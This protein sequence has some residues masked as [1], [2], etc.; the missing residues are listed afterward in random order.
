MSKKDQNNNR[1]A[2]EFEFI[3]KS[4]RILFLVGLVIYFLFFLSNAFITIL[5]PYP[6]DYAEGISLDRVIKL[7]QGIN[8]YH[9]ISTYPNIC[10]QYTPVAF[11][12][13]AFFSKI[14]GASLALGRSASLITSIIVGV[15]IYGI[16]KEKTRDNYIAITSSLLFFASPFT[17]IQSHVFGDIMAMGILFSL[18]GIYLVFKYEDSKKIYFCIPFFILAVYTKQSFITAPLASFL[19]LFLKDKKLSIK[20][21]LIYAISGLLLFWLA[22]YLTGGQFYFHTMTSNGWPFSITKMIYEYVMTIQIHLVLIGFALAFCLITVIRREYN[23]FVTYFTFSTLLAVTVGKIGGSAISYMLEP[24][25]LSCIL[26]GVFFERMEQKIKKNELATILV[27]TLL[28]LQLVS[29][30]HAPYVAD[31]VFSGSTTPTME[32]RII[33]QEVSAYMKNTSGKVLSEDAGF[34]VI[35]DKDLLVDPVLVTQ[36]HR[37]GLFDQSEILNDIQNGD[38]SLILLKFDVKE[39]EHYGHFTD[40]MIEG[41]RNNY[42]LVETIGENYIYEPKNWA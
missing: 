20:M 35:N 28:I 30:A 23:L 14:F 9:D 12:I 3:S 31:S 29:F 38:F 10:C 17:Y 8:I 5:H 7:S 24:I 19:Y 6:I 13:F 2:K 22:N 11:L 40:E 18:I 25:A 36:L 4:L 37:V 32:D 42:Y 21:A 1:G 41:I 33:G 34:V 26:F 39:V 16:V 27:F 15:I